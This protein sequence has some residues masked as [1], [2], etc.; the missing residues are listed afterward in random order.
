MLLPLGKL[1]H[2]NVNSQLRDIVGFW[3]RIKDGH[4]HYFDVGFVELV[5]DI[6][7]ELLSERAVLIGLGIERH[8]DC[9]EILSIG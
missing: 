4:R 3:P 7:L 5:L 2:V 1:E 9:G 6:F 8:N